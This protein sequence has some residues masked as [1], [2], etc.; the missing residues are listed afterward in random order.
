[1]TTSEKLAS[2]CE[3]CGPVEM[4]NPLLVQRRWYLFGLIPL[5]TFDCRLWIEDNSENW[6]VMCSS[7]RNERQPTDSAI[8]G[9]DFRKLV[10]NAND[11]DGCIAWKRNL[12]AWEIA[13]LSEGVEIRDRIEAAINDAYH[14]YCEQL[15][16]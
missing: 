9:A 15:S 7:V 6:R 12:D 11:A 14:Q 4:H 13:K 2:L 3:F 8:I 5:K 1:M 16:E 10:G